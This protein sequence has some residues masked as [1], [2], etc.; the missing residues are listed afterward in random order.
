MEHVGYEPTLTHGAIHGPG[1]SG[2]TPIMGT[3]KT[4]LRPRFLHSVVQILLLRLIDTSIDRSQRQ[5]LT[6]EFPDRIY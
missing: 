5:P 2:N 3:Y 4:R 1:Y 6:Q